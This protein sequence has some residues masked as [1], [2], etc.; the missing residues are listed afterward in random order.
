MEY[1]S[2]AFPTEKPEW[3]TDNHIVAESEA[4]KLRAFRLD[5]GPTTLIL[6]PQAGHSSHI[7]DY[8]PNQ[9]LVQ[10]VLDS[11]KGSV[12]CVEWKSAT[13]ERKGESL[14]SLVSQVYQMIQFTGPTRLIGLCQGGWLATLFTAL[15]PEEVEGLMIVAAPIDFHEGGGVIYETIID[16]GLGPYRQVV[17]MNNGIMPGNM[18]LLGWKMMHPVD[19]FFGDYLSIFTD[20]VL[21]D[22]NSLERNKKFRIWYEHTQDLAGTWYLEACEKLFLKNQLVKEELWV[23][24]KLVEL[25]NIECKVAMIAGEKDD[26]TLESHVFALGD[27]VMSNHIKETVIPNCG[28]IGCFMGTRSQDYIKESMRWLN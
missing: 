24:G 17:Q 13:Q 25:A 18:M 4:Y 12:F 1:L 23:H 10:S 14:D 26:I 7:A 28:H 16:K 3:C 9:S 22:T 20:C 19:R 5:D 21:G 27:Y 11:T 15:Y 2:V 8:G 6:P